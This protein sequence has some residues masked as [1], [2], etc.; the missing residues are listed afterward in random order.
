MATKEQID[1][2]M[3]IRDAAEAAGIMHPDV[4]AAQWALETGWG[5]SESGKYNY[6]GVKA[7]NGEP[8]NSSLDD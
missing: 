5:K 3:A 2:F 1:G 7:G 6:W 8:T 4:I